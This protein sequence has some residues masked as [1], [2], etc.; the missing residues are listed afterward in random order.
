[1]ICDP[2]VLF[3]GLRAMLFETEKPGAP[4]KPGVRRAASALALLVLGLPALAWFLEHSAAGRIGPGRAAEPPSIPAPAR[5][6]EVARVTVPLFEEAIGTVQS[7]TRIAV[8]AQVSGR[9]AEVRAAAGAPVHEGD[10]IVALDDRELSA[11][12][13]QARAQYERIK[14]FLSRQAATQQQM[15][16][17]EAEYLQAKT[18]LDHTK[19]KAP[20]GGIVVERLVE[21]GDLAWPGRTL[22]VVHDPAALRLEAQVRESLIGSI[23]RGATLDIELPALA[24]T[25][26]G[27]VAEII[28]SADPQSRSIAVWVNLDRADGVYPGMFGRLRIGVG[29]REVVQVPAEAVTRVGQIETMIVRDGPRWARRL[30]TTGATLPGGA[31]EVLS[32]LDGGETVGLT[33]GNGR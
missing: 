1:M 25:V 7:R 32:G 19:I 15:E 33:E 13:D 14:G 27:V 16:S 11:R 6:A 23:V 28:P 29:T 2:R 30:V 31:V 12:Y 18:A 10:P 22:L 24:R 26:S 9:I 3:A 5:T 4:M 17:A 8:A 21:P 20:I